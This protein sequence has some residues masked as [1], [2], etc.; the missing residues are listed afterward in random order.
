MRAENM[1]DARRLKVDVKCNFGRRRRGGGTAEIAVINGAAWYEMQFSRRRLAR[2]GR[3]SG[4]LADNGK[5]VDGGVSAW[6]NRKKAKQNDVQRDCIQRQQ[7]HALS[8]N[9][10]HGK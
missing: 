2:L 6:A 1:Q 8:P 3:R 7:C 4:R 5:R 9:A 10:A